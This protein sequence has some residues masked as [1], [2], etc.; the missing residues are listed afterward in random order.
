MDSRSIILWTAG[1]VFVG[2][3]TSASVADWRSRRIPNPIVLTLLVLGVCAS[4][5][6]R[7]EI[8]AVRQSL[9]AAALGFAI[10]IPFYALRVMGAGD[11]KLFA[12]GAAWLTPTLVIQALLITAAAGG[13]LA[14][15][16]LISEFGLGFTALRLGHLLRRPG[17]A[18]DK[19]LAMPA[20]QRH[21]P[22][23]VAMSIGLASAW[24]LGAAAH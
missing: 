3:L 2:L 7:P 6:L 4:L 10:W 12:A 11:V 22:Y 24:W 20:G 5:A 21:I 15:G 23:G 9:V 18:F 19:S 16:W 17:I 8:A 1:L 14:L 13:V